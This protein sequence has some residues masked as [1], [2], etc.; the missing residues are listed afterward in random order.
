MG[1]LTEEDLSLKLCP[2]TGIPTKGRVTLETVHG[3]YILYKF[4]PIG[5]AYFEHTSLKS[6]GN[7]YSAGSL[8]P[9][10]DWAGLCR[11]AYE[12]E[13]TGPIIQGLPEDGQYIVPET[14]EEKGQHFL[15]LFYEAG[16]NEHRKRAIFLND[17]FP[18]AFARNVEE[19][20]RIFQSLLAEGFLRHDKPSMRADVV[21]G[22]LVYF[23]G[24]LLTPAGKQEA[25]KLL[26]EHTNTALPHKVAQRQPR[27]VNEQIRCLLKHIYDD[28]PEHR[29][30]D[31]LAV[32]DFAIAHTDNA[33]EFE[34]I[35]DTAQ[36]KGWLTWGAKA[37]LSLGRVQYRD[38]RLTLPGI[39]ETANNPSNMFENMT[40]CPLT[41]VPLKGLASTEP[42][43]G[44]TQ[45]LYSFKPIG[46]AIFEFKAAVAIIKLVQQGT[47]KPRLDLAG[48][49][50]EAAEKG[51]PPL[52]ITNEIF[53]GDP[54][55]DTPITFKQKQSHFLR[56]LYETGADEYK[57]R[58]VDID[59]DFTLAFASDSK[60]FT[61]ILTSLLTEGFIKYA[62]PND[63][64]ND[65]PNGIRTQYPGMLLTPTGQQR[66]I[67]SLPSSLY[68]TMPASI[69]NTAIEKIFISH[70]SKDAGIVEEIIDLLEIMG[71]KQKQIF[72]SS[73]QGY[74]IGLGQDFLQRIKD[75]LNGNVLVLFIITSDFYSSPVSL[76]EMG[77]AWVKTTTHIP[78]VVPPLSYEDVKGVIPLTQG[79]SID[80]PLKWN[81]LKEQ[82]EQWFDIQSQD[83]MS[84]WERKRDKSIGLINRKIQAKASIQQKP[85]KPVRRG[86]STGAI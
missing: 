73:F 1:F 55:S 22:Q 75:E 25:K 49:C 52:I 53:F 85:V 81:V 8:Q 51:Q 20:S 80:E 58:N 56:L 59:Y 65:W 11:E 62:K 16:G 10:T 30:G 32:R 47:F 60:E 70:S 4:Q 36:V 78:I 15:R 57:E 76:C 84:A 54:R 13:Q 2:L 38:V 17:D 64:P 35:V 45:V 72:C 3:G 83:S 43:N 74:S 42:L 7:L 18:M 23:R 33:N 41:G 29:V 34:Q 77:A 21:D 27:D 63:T 12:L 50:R 37:T 31:L 66:V 14:F 24:V 46:E 40:T 28:S 48:L 6:L 82:L 67:K 9:L 19:F 39:E 79:F 5:I 61:R 71:V 26:A 86:S 69:P 68:V 44:S